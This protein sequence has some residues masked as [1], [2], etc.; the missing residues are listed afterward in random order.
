[1]LNWLDIDL[2]FLYNVHCVNG[3]AIKTLRVM[4]TLLVLTGALLFITFPPLTEQP[5]YKLR[6]DNVQPIVVAYFAEE[7]EATS[8]LLGIVPDAESFHG[9]LPKS[10][11]C[12]YVSSNLEGKEQSGFALVPSPPP[13]W[14]SLFRTAL[15]GELTNS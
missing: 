14:E 13:K 11:V 12:R 4:S 6:F 5:D 10:E 7:L 1:M 8:P 15:N 3:G 2:L 9:R